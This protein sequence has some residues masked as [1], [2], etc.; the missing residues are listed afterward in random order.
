MFS[1]ERSFEDSFGAQGLGAVPARRLP[2]PIPPQ[3]C[4]QTAQGPRPAEDLLPGDLVQT[5]DHGLQPLR[6]IRHPADDPAAMGRPG[7]V[8]VAAGALGP[9]CP[10]RTLALSADQ[11]VM[12]SGWAV[13]CVA[14]E[15]EALVT[16][17][18]LAGQ[19]GVSM[20]PL[21]RSGGPGLGFDRPEIV[22]VEGLAILCE[23]PGTPQLPRMALSGAEAVTA[24]AM[25]RTGS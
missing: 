12:L 13:E 1:Q 21:G 20:L 4:V 3:A 24:V 14:G 9:G 6:T 2:R 17:R 15:V 25:V 5:V 8:R 7:M 18:D 10:A 16:L 22:M 19:P 11:R 23:V